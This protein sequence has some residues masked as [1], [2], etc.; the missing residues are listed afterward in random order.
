MSCEL[1]DGEEDSILPETRSRVK[2][3]LDSGT[4]IKCKSAKGIISVHYAIFCGDCLKES[5][6]KRFKS[7]IRQQPLQHLPN[8]RVLVAYSG[9]I[10]S[11]LMMYLMSALLSG[12]MYKTSRFTGLVVCHI[13]ESAI[14]GTGSTQQEDVWKCILDA[15]HV[16]EYVVKSLEDIFTNDAAPMSSSPRDRLLESLA[17]ASKQSSREDLIQCYQRQLL[18]QVARE[19]EC[20]YIALGDTSTRLAI[21]VISSVS[22]GRGLGVPDLV[23]SEVTMTGCDG[24]QVVVIKPMKE[25]S[26]KEIAMLVNLYKIPIPTIARY[27]TGLPA[28]SS[29]D[30]LTEDFVLSLLK[31]FPSTTSTVLKTALKVQTGHRTNPELALASLVCYGCANV[32]KESDVDKLPP[33]V[34]HNVG[35]IQK[36]IVGRERDERLKSQISEFLIEDADDS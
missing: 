22:K 26:S 30:R 27:D 31:D 24:S 36:Q 21:K 32:I 33:F 12:N 11:S 3:L 16:V 2:D 9:G 8:G 29:I 5:A 23:N 7:T 14:A 6:T 19:Y 18:M 13:D 34:K 28:K 15:R 17:S 4:C 10:S 25:F 35:A 20:P 1:P